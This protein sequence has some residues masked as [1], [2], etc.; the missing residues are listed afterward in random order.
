[1]VSQGEKRRPSVS[2]EMNRAS[3]F[4]CAAGT[5][6]VHASKDKL[7]AVVAAGRVRAKRMAEIK[8]AQE[9][10]WAGLAVGDVV[11]LDPQITVEE[12][13][14]PLVTQSGEAIRLDG[15]IKEIR[16]NT[17]TVLILKLVAQGFDGRPMHGISRQVQRSLIEGKSARAASRWGTAVQLQTMRQ[18][19][20]FWS[21]GEEG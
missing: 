19:P 11:V 5:C 3:C 12:Y 16:G 20:K 14:L 17:A 10:Q 6:S 1:M 9:Q 13:G 4:R 15:T 18:Q 2:L 21:E 7:D 8:I